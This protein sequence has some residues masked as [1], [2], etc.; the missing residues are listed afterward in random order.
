MRVHPVTG[1]RAI[2][3]NAEFVTSIAGLKDKEYELL[4]KFLI[5][6][7][8]TGH[9]F[10]CRVR[11]ERHSVVMF[12]G[13]TTL[14]ESKSYRALDKMINEFFLDTATVDYDSSKQARHIFRLASMTEKPIPVQE[15]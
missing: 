9:D 12:D 13:R 11:W 10:Q 2:F 15:H 6:H 4:M 8:Q 3:L 5:D 14:R 1:E 7:I